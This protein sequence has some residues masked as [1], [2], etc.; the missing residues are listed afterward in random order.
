M[1]ILFLIWNYWPGLQGGAERQAR[2]VCHEMARRGCACE[3]VTARIRREW[4]R[5]SDD[6]GI[7]VRRLGLLIPFLLG[8]RDAVA[9]G[10]RAA[11]GQ[12]WKS[13]GQVHRFA[14]SAVYWATA[15]WMWMARL[16]FIVEFLFLCRTRRLSADIIHLHEPSWLGGVAQLA[17]LRAGFRVLC[18]EATSPALPVI[19]YDTPFRSLLSRARRLPQYIAMADYTG[20]Q[21]VEAGIP[22]E[23]IHH[24]PSG[25]HTPPSPSQGMD[26]W[27][28]LY[29]ANFSQGAAWKAF[30]I[31]FAAWIRI[32]QQEPRARLY[33]VG[34]G[35]SSQWKTMLTASGVA[36]TVVFT[37]TVE[38]I[39]VYYNQSAIFLLPS[40]VEGLSNA[41]LEAQ[42]WGL[43]CVVS[44]IPGNKAVVDDGVNGVVVPVG[45]VGTLAAA[46]T[47]L[48]QDVEGRRRL[49]QAA[50][51][52]AVARY[53][54]DS[55]GERLMG[56]YKHILG[57][58]GG[59]GPHR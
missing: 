23:N 26:T 43:A 8:V 37:G 56:I 41:L 16:D 13:P 40:R 10:L 55:V 31:L 33:A 9:R 54:I 46:V 36:D 32:A 7:G 18:Q 14:D 2:L 17:A 39:R 19:G 1:K 34:G 22:R 57:G 59:T 51:D 44:D 25:V 48:L 38:D 11:T 28:V 53:S 49:G 5:Q 42:M 24:L 50:R 12:R 52:R 3:V 45:D 27:N 29:V 15:P 20:T 30:D 47:G 21:L 58:N 35:D 4:P 6:Q